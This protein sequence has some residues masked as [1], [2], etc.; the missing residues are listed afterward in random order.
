MFGENYTDRGNLS[1]FTANS[2]AKTASLSYGVATS[3]LDLA[4]NPTRGGRCSRS[5]R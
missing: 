1:C 2:P 3:W 4:H 5:G